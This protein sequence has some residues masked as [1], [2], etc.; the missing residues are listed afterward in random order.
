MSP[1]RSETPVSEGEDFGT[2]YREHFREGSVSYIYCSCFWNCSMQSQES[3]PRGLR[4]LSSIMT[5]GCFKLP[6]EGLSL[7]FSLREKPTCVT[8]LGPFHHEERNDT[9]VVT[10]Q[11]VCSICCNSLPDSV[12]SSVNLLFE[13]K[14]ICVQ[15][16]GKYVFESFEMN[17]TVHLVSCLLISRLPDVSFS[18]VRGIDQ[19]SK[20]TIVHT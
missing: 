17:L 14:I 16:D 11:R 8:I 13:I 20:S 15:Q 6:G 9:L 4:R 3:Y 1:H 19:T 7:G 18:N 10:G 2:H 12:L 5:M